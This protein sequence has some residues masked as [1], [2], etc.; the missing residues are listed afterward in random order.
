MN[1]SEPVILQTPIPGHFSTFLLVIFVH[2][3]MAADNTSTG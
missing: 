3:E 1:C 2:F